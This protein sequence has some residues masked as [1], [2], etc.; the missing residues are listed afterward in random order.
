MHKACTNGP[1]T[2]VLK[3]DG[4][5]CDLKG[6]HGSKSMLSQKMLHIIGRQSDN[7]VRSQKYV[8]WQFLLNQ[9][10]RAFLS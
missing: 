3:H 4:F 9:A 7:Y 2:S 10:I 8:A 1:G 6:M 5:T